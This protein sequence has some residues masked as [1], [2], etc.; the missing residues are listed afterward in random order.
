MGEPKSLLSQ[1]SIKHY[2]HFLKELFYKNV[3]DRFWEK[4]KNFCKITLSAE[5]LKW[6]KYDIRTL[7]VTLEKL[8]TFP[9]KIHKF[10]NVKLKFLP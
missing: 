10:L 1:S 9:Q 2:T 3:G 6:Q 4:I 7:Y 5:V 8:R